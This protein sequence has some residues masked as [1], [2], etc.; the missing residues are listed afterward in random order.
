MRASVRNGFF[1]FTAKR[2]GF[3]PFMYCDILNLVT[4]GVGNL[5]DTSAHN[6][7]DTS[8]KAMAP[9]M[10]LPWFIKG[11]GWTSN[12]PVVDRRATQDEVASAWIATKLQEQREPGFNKKGGFAYKNLTP[13]TLDMQGLKD[14]FQRTEDK[15]AATLIKEFPNFESLPADA[16]GAMMSMA[17]AMGPAYR[18]ALGFK[19]FGAAIDTED[20]QQIVD[21]KLSFFKGGGGTLEAPA[22]RNKENLQMFQIAADVKAKNADREPWHFLGGTTPLDVAPKGSPAVAS[23]DFAHLFDMSA[24]TKE[25]LKTGAVVTTTVVGVG[26]V[27][28]VALSVA[29]A[30]KWI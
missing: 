19:A 16:Q 10:G 18:S 12:N 30:K 1:D 14:L 5:I 24:A 11:T 25:K 4:T 28:I 26:A 7:F 27:A 8:A 13:V 21:K 2:E 15:F 20:F 29:K 17:W 3:T 9:A 6:S 22:G 23:L